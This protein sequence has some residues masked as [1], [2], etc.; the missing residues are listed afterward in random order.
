[1]K[2]IPLRQLTVCSITT[3]NKKQDVQDLYIEN[4]GTPF[5]DAPSSEPSAAGLT[6]I[7]CNYDCHVCVCISDKKVTYFFSLSIAEQ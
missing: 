5:N 6:Y 2:S 4:L 7:Y 1:M 3:C